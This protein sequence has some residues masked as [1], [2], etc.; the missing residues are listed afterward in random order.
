MTI[1]DVFRREATELGVP[2]TLVLILSVGSVQAHAPSETSSDAPDDRRDMP[3][4]LP[5]LPA[6]DDAASNTTTETQ[7]E[8]APEEPTTPVGLRLEAQLL[9]A[10]TL[11]F[12]GDESGAAWGFGL[13]YGA[14]WGAIPI[15]IGL[16]F[17]CRTITVGGT[18]IRAFGSVLVAA[19]RRARHR[20]SCGATTSTIAPVSGDDAAD[21]VRFPAGSR[22]IGE[23][24]TVTPL[25]VAGADATRVASATLRAAAMGY[26]LYGRTRA[27]HAGD[28]ACLALAVAQAIAAEPVYTEQA[29]RAFATVAT[30]PGRA[31]RELATKTSAG[32][33]ALRRSRWDA[34]AFSGAWRSCS[35]A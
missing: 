16:D 20:R 21:A 30:R 31:S 11:P 23:G 24:T 27:L 19:P 5:D 14:G 2:L 7:E 3:Q 17:T 34:T 33:S 15:L 8:P 4:T 35:P 32:R 6:G 18:R 9:L 29:V 25:A 10:M 12:G 26:P 28:I 22:E 13:T 1:P